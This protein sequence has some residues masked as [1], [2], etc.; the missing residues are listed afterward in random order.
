MRNTA[1]PTTV[2]FA[3]ARMDEFFSAISHLPELVGRTYGTSTAH[4]TAIQRSVSCV[5]R[6]SSAGDS[7]SP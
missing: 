2:A 5:Q 4:A 1:P 6:M 3:A 7:S